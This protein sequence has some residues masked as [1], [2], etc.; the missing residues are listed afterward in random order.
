MLTTRP[1]MTRAIRSTIEV[2]ETGI[3]ASLSL[4]RDN[5]GRG[6]GLRRRRAVAIHPCHAEL[7]SA[8]SPQPRGWVTSWTL[9]QVQGDEKAQAS[10]ARPTRPGFSQRTRASAGGL[11]G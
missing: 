11:P 6:L 1:A 7:V 3:R 9:N 2:L 5:G 4:R 10:S 8:S